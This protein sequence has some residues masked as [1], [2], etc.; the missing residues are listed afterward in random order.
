M[1]YLRQHL[2]SLCFQLRLRQTHTYRRNHHGSMDSY[3]PKEAILKNTTHQR[4]EEN[5]TGQRVTRAWL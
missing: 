1:K 3:G 4:V 5:E 2:T